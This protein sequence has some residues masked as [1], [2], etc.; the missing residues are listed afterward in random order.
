MKN[1]YK[2]QPKLKKTIKT[3]VKANIKTKTKNRKAKWTNKKKT[4]I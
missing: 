4:E 3:K 2:K 1:E